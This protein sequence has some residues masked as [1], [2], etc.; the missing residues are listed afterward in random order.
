[1]SKGKNFLSLFYL[2]PVDIAYKLFYPFVF[3][4]LNKKVIIIYNMYK[5]Y[6]FLLRLGAEFPKRS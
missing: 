3:T 5:P 6:H 1:M 4:Q 2:I